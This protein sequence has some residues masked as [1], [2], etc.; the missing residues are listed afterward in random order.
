MVWE[1][2]EVANFILGLAVF[3]LTA[4]ILIMLRKADEILLKAKLFLGVGRGFIYTTWYYLLGIVILIALH[5]LAWLAYSKDI[6]GAYFIYCVTKTLYLGMLC[7]LLIQWFIVARDC[8]RS[9]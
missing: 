2:L 4:G 6:S 5:S 1:Y 7:M 9:G 3:G 8:L